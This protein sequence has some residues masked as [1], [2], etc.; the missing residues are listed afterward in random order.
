MLECDTLQWC[1]IYVALM[2]SKF[3]KEGITLWDSSHT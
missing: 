2:G 3:D 1:Y